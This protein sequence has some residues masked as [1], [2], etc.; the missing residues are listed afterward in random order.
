MCWAKTKKG[1]HKGGIKVHTVTNVDETVP[2]MVWFSEAA[3]NDHLLLNKLKPDQN[4]IYV[5][6]KGYNDYKAFKKFTDSGTGFITRIKDTAV[7]DVIQQKEIEEHIHSGVLEDIVI[8]IYVNEKAPNN[9]LSF[10]KSHF[11]TGRL[12]VN[13]RL[14]QT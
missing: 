10:E 5:F 4:T 1:K 11:M 12:N 6:D 14:L 9:K 13:S 8:E 3:K 7:Y 2:K